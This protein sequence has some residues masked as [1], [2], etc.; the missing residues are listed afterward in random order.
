MQECRSEAGSV[1][2]IHHRIPLKSGNDLEIPMTTYFAVCNEQDFD[3][4]QLDLIIKPRER[5]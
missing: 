1:T 5:F 2:D 3:K 4:K